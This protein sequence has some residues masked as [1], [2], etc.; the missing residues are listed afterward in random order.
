MT[1]ADFP[2]NMWKAILPAI[3]MMLVVAAP[4]RS[5]TMAPSGPPVSKELKQ[6]LDRLQRHYRDTRSF[7]AKFSEEIATVGALIDWLSARSPRH[8]A[9]S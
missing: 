5:E 1:V 7:S 2:E 8:A 9:A 3:L 6:V 4:A